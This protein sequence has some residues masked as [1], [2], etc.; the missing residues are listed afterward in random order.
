MDRTPETAGGGAGKA[1][2]YPR[3]GTEQPHEGTETTQH[4][5][6]SLNPKQ[7]RQQTTEVAYTYPY[8]YA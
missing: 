6:R 1:P 4:G 5:G 3:K 2:Y 7:T 8:A